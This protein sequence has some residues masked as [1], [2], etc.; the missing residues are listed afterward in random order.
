[1][2]RAAQNG[3]FE[4]PLS[5]I[6]K[7]GDKITAQQ[8]T[9][10][11]DGTVTYGP[12]GSAVS[13]TT[14]GQA[15]EGGAAG[16]T[17]AAAAV[18]PIAENDST[19]T[20]TVPGAKDGQVR[21]CIDS[22]EVQVVPV[23]STGGYSYK[24]TTPLKA[25]QTV[26][27]Q[28]I[29]TKAGDPVSYDFPLSLPVVVGAAADCTG[30][31]PSAT[32]TTQSGTASAPTL[33]PLD[34]GDT[35]VSGTLTGAKGTEV[36]RI[37]VN[38]KDA[39]TTNAIKVSKS[40]NF[41]GELTTPLAKGQTVTA[42]TAPASGSTEYGPFSNSEEVGNA[43][44]SA[45]SWGRVRVSLSGGGVISQNQGNFSQIS[46]YG[47]FNA[48]DT[49][50]MGDHCGNWIVKDSDDSKAPPQ[51]QGL[52]TA[53]DQSNSYKC[54]NA[55]VSRKVNFKR[56]FQVNSFFDIR[57][58]AIPAASCQTAGSTSTTTSSAGNS[59]PSKG[60]S[61]A[62]SNSSG[63]S[64]SVTC[65]QADGSAVTASGSANTFVTT[66]KAAIVAGGLYFPIYLGRTSWEREGHRHALY[67]APIFKG[68]LQTLVQSAQSSSSASVPSSTLGAET[69]FYFYSMGSRFGLYKFHDEDRNRVAPD[70]ILYLDT[71]VGKYQNL[72]NYTSAGV[73]STGPLPWTVALEG[74]F[75]IPKVPVFL[76]FNSTTTVGQGTGDL[77]FLFGTSFDL[78]CLLQKVGVNNPGIASCDNGPSK[79]T[80]SATSSSASGKQ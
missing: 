5:V 63:N 47:D 19:I 71:T 13:V 26:Q 38:G 70:Q 37:C 1:V 21:I 3:T 64:G 68:G 53:K 17:T 29:S 31:Q 78:G 48:D 55:G 30:E 54:G 46:I 79:G 36:I 44:A 16:G 28:Q 15:C 67:F 9:V 61:Q 43:L 58:T 74:R 11:A 51:G 39:Q 25:N 60:G 77:R 20:G 41:T 34:P 57:L 69:F 49:W 62:T 65:T 22:K 7:S 14:T 4:V 35:T 45:Y 56:G 33:N 80:T 75:N 59:A 12:F 52:A 72:P 6:L 24:L 32:G 76:G 8:G 2:G 50:Y 27:T 23:H 73:A 18:N 40:G 42:Q 66:P 10:A